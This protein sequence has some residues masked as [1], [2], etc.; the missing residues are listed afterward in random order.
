LATGQD[1]RTGTEQD[2]NRIALCGARRFASEC[3]R[4]RSPSMTAS[5]AI[6]ADVRS[7][8][9]DRSVSDHRALVRHL[10]DLFVVNAAALRDAEIA[11]FGEV[12]NELIREIDTAARALLA[13]RLASVGNA[14]AALMRTLAWDDEAEVA[15]PVLMH[16]AQLDDST[17]E[18]AARRKGQ[19]HLLAISR[20]ESLSPPVTD[21]LVEHGDAQ[22]LLSVA[23]NAGARF[24]EQGMERLIE[25]ARGND[26]LSE[27]IGR[28]KDIPPPAFAQLLQ[29]ASEQVRAK[30]QAELPYP[31]REIEQSVRDAARHVARKHENQIR[32]AG[33][34]HASV[35]KLHTQ[36]ELDDEQLR[37]FAEDGLLEEVRAG[38]SLISGLPL[39][40][41]DQAL[42]QESGEMLLVIARA[43]GLAWATIERTLRLPI[44]RRP[45]TPSEIRH[46]LARYEKLGEATARDIMRF[47]K[48]RA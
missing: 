12:L 40:L 25:R 1:G 4:R 16:S 46:C 42:R 43:T 20:R 28:R 9:S 34:I 5:G 29:V 47:Y 41:I 21:A 17:L 15:C 35:E 23:G 38:L 8:V 6:L 11:L 10:T 32:D 13:L 27:R 31:A 3:M 48:A 44:W 24:S 18:A 45:A 22:V 39:P 36:G 37:S 30:L 14:P 33:A 2:G 7:A 19:E 26:G